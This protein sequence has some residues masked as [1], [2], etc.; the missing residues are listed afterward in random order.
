MTIKFVLGKSTTWKCLFQN[1][2]KTSCFSNKSIEL[3]G[4]RESAL[5]AKIS[6]FESQPPTPVNQVRLQ[7]TR[8]LCSSVCVYETRKKII[9][10]SALRRARETLAA[11]AGRS[12]LC[13]SA[14]A[15]A[16]TAVRATQ[17]ARG[18]SRSA[19]GG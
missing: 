13:G 14:G 10:L 8:S 18:P 7:V 3:S 5:G 12:A 6:G 17:D 4:L 15:R 11:V 1:E 2:K 19:K 16:A 9:F